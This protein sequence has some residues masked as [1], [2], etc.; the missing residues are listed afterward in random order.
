MFY[1]GVWP[2]QPRKRKAVRVLGRGGLDSNKI[3]FRD[4]AAATRQTKTL[5]NPNKFEQRL[6]IAVQGACI[7]W[8]NA[9]RLGEIRAPALCEIRVGTLSYR[10]AYAMLE[11]RLNE[12]ALDADERE[13]ILIV[14][15]SLRPLIYED[16]QG[17]C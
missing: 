15:E 7:G 12:G 16:H 10:L 3:L 8:F 1:N 17:P 4:L 2:S 13:E 11:T 9:A 14:I 5:T 6:N